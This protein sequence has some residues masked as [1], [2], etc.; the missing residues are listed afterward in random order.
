VGAWGAGP[1]E[2]D[3]ALD[4]VAELREVTGSELRSRL[5]SALALPADGYL[6]LPEAC[7]AVAAAGLVAVARGTA[8]DDLDEQITGLAQSGQLGDSLRIREL[9]VA[10]LARV[11]GESSEWRELWSASG[12]SGEADQMLA[13]PRRHWPDP[14]S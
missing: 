4:F 7:A 11:N 9:A 14:V 8:F 12:S 5:E 6:E 10:A 3:D 1:F 2:N 13:N